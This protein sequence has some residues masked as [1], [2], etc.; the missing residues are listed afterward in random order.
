MDI[1]EG[2][3]FG[4]VGTENHHTVP[5]NSIYA[6]HFSTNR[7]CIFVYH[8]K[9]TSRLYGATIKE[10]DQQ[11]DGRFI[12]VNKSWIIKVSRFKKLEMDTRENS[13]LYVDGVIHPIRCSRRRRM[14]VKNYFNAYTSNANWL[15]YLERSWLYTK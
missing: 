12:Q 9:G 14:E 8:D 10:L 15:K 1:S 6:F 4:A 3:T 13:T 7:H 11:L 5:F 2:I